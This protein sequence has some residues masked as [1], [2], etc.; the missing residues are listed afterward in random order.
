MI[1]PSRYVVRPADESETPLIMSTWL[2][3]AWE[4]R[5]GS[6]KMIPHDVFMRGERAVAERLLGLYSATVAT[7]P[8]VPDEVLGWACLDRV[9][10]ALHFCYVKAAYRR[11]GVMRDLLTLVGLIPGSLTV[12]AMTPDVAAWMRAGRPISFNPY[13]L[14]VIP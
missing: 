5:K 4:H 9:G 3:Q 11:Q 6:A 10:R 12:S 2:R 1:S 8:E 14:S 13:L 7:L